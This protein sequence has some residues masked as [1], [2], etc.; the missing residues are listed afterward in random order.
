MIGGE[1]NSRLKYLLEGAVPEIPAAGKW[2]RVE[3]R[4]RRL[5]R[6]RL[7]LRAGSAL[8]A[9]AVVVPAGLWV[10]AEIVDP[11]QKV[12]ITDPRGVETGGPRTPDR[13][14][15]LQQVRALRDDLVAGKITIDWAAKRTPG[16]PADALSAL[17]LLEAAL[18]SPDMIVF[19]KDGADGVALASLVASWSEVESA[20]LVSKEEALARLKE[21]LKDH[22]EILDGLVSNPL[23][24]SV[25]V[26]LHDAG[27]APAVEARLGGESGVESVRYRSH[28]V[29]ATL[30]TVQ[31][32]QSLS[33]PAGPE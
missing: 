28:D 24:A 21:D 16:S 23:P 14:K 33:R 9:L 11:G 20:S 12:V 17:E 31:L 27:T 1:K 29:Q 10:R 7:F 8:L 5:R 19:V 32:L 22:P 13:E 6:R 26:F 4:V 30:K 2:S 15:L 18:L 25:E 3:V